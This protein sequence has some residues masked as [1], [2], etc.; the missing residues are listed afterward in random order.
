MNLFFF[1]RLTSSSLCMSVFLKMK[2]RRN[3]DKM[4]LH[5]GGSYNENRYSL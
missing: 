2:K 4:N 3:F 1:L 5:K